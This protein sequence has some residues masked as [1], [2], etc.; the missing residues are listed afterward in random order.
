MFGDLIKAA[1]AAVGGPKGVI[2]EPADS[3]TDH[4]HGRGLSI[5]DPPVSPYSTPDEIVEWMDELEAMD[6]DESVVSALES[7]WL[8]LKASQD[9]SNKR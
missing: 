3:P 6:Q 9:Y 2:R 1:M 7:A 8:M 5:I 4:Y